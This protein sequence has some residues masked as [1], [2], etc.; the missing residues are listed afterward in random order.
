MDSAYTTFPFCDFP[1]DLVR[2]IIEDV[3]TDPGYSTRYR[4]SFALISR[5][6]QGWVESILYRQI[7]LRA[8]LAL[9]RLHRTVKSHPSKPAHFFPSNVKTFF[10]GDPIILNMAIAFEILSECRGITELSWC[11]QMGGYDRSSPTLVGRHALWNSLELRRL[12]IAESLFVDTH[13]HFSFAS[14]WGSEKTHNPF[15]RNITHLDLHHWGIGGW[16]W[17]TLSLLETLTH[18]CFSSAAG[19]EYKRHLRRSL[20]TIVPHFPS[21]LVV[22][23]ASIIYEPF[24][25][26][27]R[28]VVLYLRQLDIRIVV[29]IAEHYYRR[30]LEKGPEGLWVKRETVWRWGGGEAARKDNKQAF[31]DRGVGIVQRRKME[32]EEAERPLDG[33]PELIS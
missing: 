20:A 24:N 5:A 32:L 30:E 15:F 6:V 14:G 10:I 22:C 1:E 28:D 23:V 18:L 8:P 33:V 31:W 13:K 16:S 26:T 27:H 7:V 19:K 2:L 4:W 21:S 25:H 3:V 11:T 12:S 17:E 9:Y 29:A